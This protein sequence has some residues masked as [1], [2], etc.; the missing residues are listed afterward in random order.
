MT[1]M[2]VDDSSAMRGVMREVVA[3]WAGG[4]VE[5]TDGAECLAQFAATQP[6]WTLMDVSM[7]R[8][9][10]LDATRAIRCVWPEARILL[11]TQQ[12]SAGVSAAALEAGAIGCLGKEYLHQ[13]PRLLGFDG[14]G[15]N[16]PGIE[17]D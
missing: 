8:M 2:I 9:D 13:V 11:V 3:P 5:C 12:P 14:P 6:D 4:V 15:T 10:G 17:V 7:P 16:S 1:F